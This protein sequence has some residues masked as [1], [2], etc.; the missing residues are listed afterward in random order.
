MVGGKC[1]IPPP[2]KTFPQI[3]IFTPPDGGKLLI[4]PQAVFF[5]QLF[6]PAERRGGEETMKVSG[7]VVNAGSINKV[8]SKAFGILSS[9]VLA[10]LP[11]PCTGGTCRNKKSITF[12]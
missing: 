1:Q 11:A 6:P 2:D 12:V 8:P 3:F 7:Y 10:I 5:K 9:T 4:P